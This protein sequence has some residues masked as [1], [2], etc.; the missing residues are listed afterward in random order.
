MTFTVMNDQVPPG[1]P[2]PK[3]EDAPEGITKNYVCL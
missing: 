2:Q 1:I 3:G